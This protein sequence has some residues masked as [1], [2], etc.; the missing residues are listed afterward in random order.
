MQAE[1]DTSLNH[2]LEVET[3]Q[4]KKSSNPFF[5]HINPKRRSLQL[6]YLL[7]TTLVQCFSLPTELKETKKKFN[8]HRLDFIDFWRGLMFVASGKGYFYIFPFSGLLITVRRR[9]QWDLWNTAGC[10]TILAKKK[11]EKIISR[12]FLYNPIIQNYTTYFRSQ[13]YNL[14]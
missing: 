9:Q 14:P 1:Q 2:I 13:H 3:L 12:S 6:S 4:R 11:S 5:S 10:I 7:F 8:F